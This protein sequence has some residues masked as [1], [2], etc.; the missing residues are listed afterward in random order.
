MTL[1]KQCTPVLTGSR[2]RVFG[3]IIISCQPSAI[4]DGHY[5]T[6]NKVVVVAGVSFEMCSQRKVKRIVSE[7]AA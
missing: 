5:T 7:A 3:Y 1:V 6:A 2:F 4:G